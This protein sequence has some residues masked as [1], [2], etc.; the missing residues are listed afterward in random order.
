MIEGMAAWVERYA[1]V[2]IRPVVDADT[3][4]STLREAFAARGPD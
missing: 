4:L 1:D 3:A 2:E